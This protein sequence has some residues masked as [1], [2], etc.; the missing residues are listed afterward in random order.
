MATALVLLAGAC[1]SDDGP[2]PAPPGSGS[3][4]PGGSGGTVGT[5]PTG[6]TPVPAGLRFGLAEEPGSLD[7]IDGPYDRAT[8]QLAR[9]VFDPLVAYDERLDLQPVLAEQVTPSDDQRTWTI[10]LRPG[11][12]FSDGRP[13]NAGAVAAMLDRA[14]RSTTWA[15][16]LDL[17]RGVE[18]VDEHK[19]VVQM[20]GPW[21]T[22][23]HVLAGPLGL[24][25]LPAVPGGD[26]PPGPSAVVGTGPFRIDEWT[27]GERVH[28]VRTAD[29]WRGV[30]ARAPSI[31]FSFVANATARSAMLIAGELDL[32]QFDEPAAMA[33]IGEAE[34]RGAVQ[35]H[36]DKAGETPE[37]VLALATDRAPFDEAPA[38]MAL[39][40]AIDRDAL[41]R[42]VFNGQ[43]PPAEGPFSEGSRWFGQAQ[44]PLRDPAAAKEEL[45]RR[46]DA[47]VPLGF[48]L[49]VESTPINRRLVEE[50][51]FQ[52]QEVGIQLRPVWLD[53]VELRA[54]VADWRFTAALVP[55]FDGQHPDADYATLHSRADGAGLKNPWIDQALEKARRSADVTTQA[56]A[57]QV[58]Q[59]QLAREMPF[60]FLVRM[61]DSLAASPRVQGTGAG[62]LPNGRPSLPQLQGTI[63][64][65]TVSVG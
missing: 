9:A 12:R 31:T 22:F 27:P 29:Y 44:W 1:R 11:V 8:Y 47:T 43:F 34:R 55:L 26:A 38:R 23:A 33:E 19:V 42:R 20:R 24:V 10:Q 45:T 2:G 7:P 4:G 35:V 14:R 39:A 60:V 6:T 36:A 59:D 48:D 50:L 18:A 15:T 41:A 40:Q 25:M 46:A 3:P 52:L 57:F 58:V 28:L 54:R 21:S 51:G 56:E 30:P 17:I 37:L 49:L 63:G 16:E 61:R 5:A 13:F 65:E 62:V 32:A 64:L 53:R